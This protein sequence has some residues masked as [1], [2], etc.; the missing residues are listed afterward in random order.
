VCDFS[1]YTS[2]LAVVD[3]VNLLNIC[4]SHFD[5][6]VDRHG[7]YKVETIGESYMVSC[8][9]PTMTEFHAEYIGDFALDM[10]ET[11]KK[12]DF[13]PIGGKKI[14][15]KIGRT[16]LLN[17]VK[18]TTVQALTLVHALERWSVNGHHVSVCLAT[19]SIVHREWRVI[20]NRCCYTV[21]INISSP[22]QP[23]S[24][25][26][27]PLSKDYMERAAP[28]KFKFKHRGMVNLKVF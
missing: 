6:L 4:Y 26:C 11:A 14:Q 24:I 16:H 25:Q 15:V 10:L 23:M 19:P 7:V 1:T 28:G 27:G 12:I 13:A 20:I 21:S 9:V 5:E 3:I 18:T 2:K 8:G 17:S 22:L